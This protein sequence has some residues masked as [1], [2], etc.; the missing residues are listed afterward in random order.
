MRVEMPQPAFVAEAGAERTAALRDKG[1]KAPPPSSDS[2]S[3]SKA[4]V[5]QLE[6]QH[7]VSFRVGANQ[8]IFFVVIDDQTGEVVREVPPEEVRHAGEQISK[9]LEMLVAPHSTLSIVT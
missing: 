2:A 5:I 8:Q 3:K 1:G 9:F 4:A 6:S 7:S